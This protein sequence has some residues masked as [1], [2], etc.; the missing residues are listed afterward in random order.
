MLLL[1]QVMHV[2]LWDLLPSVRQLYRLDSREREVCYT[3][4]KPH[5]GASYLSE[6]RFHEYHDNSPGNFSSAYFWR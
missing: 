4:N 1:V 6:S 2:V 5:E 3:H